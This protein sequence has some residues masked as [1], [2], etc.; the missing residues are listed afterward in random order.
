MENVD[1]V[2]AESILE[3]FEGERRVPSPSASTDDFFDLD[4]KSG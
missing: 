1:E 4:K 2:S 3:T